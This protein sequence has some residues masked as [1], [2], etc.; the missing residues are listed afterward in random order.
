MY[1]VQCMCSL[2]HFIFSITGAIKDIRDKL[3]L[4]GKMFKDVAY[5]AQLCLKAMNVIIN[6]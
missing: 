5:A 2:A 3:I 1:E 6:K 4:Y